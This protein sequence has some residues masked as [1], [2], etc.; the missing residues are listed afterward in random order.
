MSLRRRGK[1]KE[2]RQIDNIIRT[3]RKGER[4]LEMMYP[5]QRD[6]SGKK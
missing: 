3:E 6:K 5:R 1:E 4:K 2:V